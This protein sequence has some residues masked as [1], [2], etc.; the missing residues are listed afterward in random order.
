VSQEQDRN[1]WGKVADYLLN[2]PQARKP[3]A[4]ATLGSGCLVP[5]LVLC[6]VLGWVIS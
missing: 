2:D 6:L 3:H 5:V 1:D 4:N